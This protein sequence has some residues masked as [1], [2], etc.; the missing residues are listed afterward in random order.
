MRTRS[1][2]LRALRDQKLF[3][4]RIAKKC[5]KGREENRPLSVV[6][7]LLFLFVATF[8]GAQ[9]CPRNVIVT[10][11]D[12]HGL[13]ISNLAASNFKTFYR[14]KPLIPLSASF[15]SDP[16]TRTFLLLDTAASMGG[17]GAQGIAKWKIA[18]MAASEFL[19][20]APPQAEVSLF[21]F[22]ATVGKT[23]H[24]GDGRKSM[25]DWIDSPESIRAS[26][27][28]GKAALHR[29]LLDMVKTLEPTRPGDA[30]YLVSD[31]RNDLK[32]SMASSVAEELQSNGVRLFSFSLNDAGESD[33][34]SV[35]EGEHSETMP[36]PS[37]GPKE[38]ADL[39][40]ASG[41]LELTLHPGSGRVGQSFGK[42]NYDYDEKSRQEARIA[43]SAFETAISN[44]Y[45]L[46]V[47]L[48][49]DARGLG[50]WQVEIVDGQ[51]KTRK[52][53]TLSYPGRI[54]GCVA[55]PVNL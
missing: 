2:T 9:T 16:A 24:S 44:F 54:P 28:A 20:A 49:E 43:A 12:A 17:L 26:S 51:G 46:A 48:P 42:T 21:T 55:S 45:V 22:S 14:G 53:V 52:D 37:P 5:R 1:R 25:Q 41:G 38:L 8:S 13:P 3:T 23:F 33:L 35:D 27:L 39:V 36:P 47:N 40:R 19:L 30:I 32:L 15:H 29:T 31:G 7:M 6:L 18:R 50:E 34:Y 11:L 10:V 4:A